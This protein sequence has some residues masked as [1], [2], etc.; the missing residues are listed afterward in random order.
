MDYRILHSTARGELNNPQ[1]QLELYKD[2]PN[3]IDGKNYID[4]TN[5]QSNWNRHANQYFNDY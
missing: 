5:M 2:V 4:A 1:W 3:E